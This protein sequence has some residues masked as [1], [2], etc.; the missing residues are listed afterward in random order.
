MSGKIYGQIS[1]R[2]RK[3]R[4][5]KE[6]RGEI[7]AMPDIVDPEE[8]IKR[9]GSGWT[10]GRPIGTV[11]EE[12]ERK[13]WEPVYAEWIGYGSEGLAAKY[14]EEKKKYEQ[15]REAY[16]NQTLAS[17]YVPMARAMPGSS[18]MH[19]GL[20]AKYDR[21]N[22]ERKEYLERMKSA[23][24]EW[25]A[26]EARKQKEE[27]LRV[28][29][30][31]KV[32]TGE[33]G[34]IAAENRTSAEK[35]LEGE[36][37]WSY[38]TEYMTEEERERFAYYYGTDRKEAE[39]YLELL[40]EMRLY[41]K[42]RESKE[43]EGE[44]IAEEIAEIDS[45]LL[46]GLADVGLAIAGGVTDAVTGLANFGKMVLGEEDMIISSLSH[47]NGLNIERVKEKSWM[48]G[49]L[50][51]FTSGVTASGLGVGVS[52]VTGNPLAGAAVMGAQ[53]SGNT[54]ARE[55]ESGKEADDARAYSLLIGIGTGTLQYLLGGIRAFG[56]SGGYGAKAA[57]K[58]NKALGGVVKQPVGRSAL[59][60]IAKQMKEMGKEAFEEY[61]ETTLEPVYR[62][63]IYDEENELELL[64]VEA[65]ENAF[66][67]ALTAGAL[68]LILPESGVERN[69]TIE[70][71]AADTRN[72]PDSIRN[73][74]DAADTRNTPNSIRNM[75]DAADMRNTPD[76]VQNTPDAADRA[77]PSPE[78]SA[79]AKGVPETRGSEL[80]KTPEPERY[81]KQAHESFDEGGSGSESAW[82]AADRGSQTQ[83]LSEDGRTG[84][85][86]GRK[87][88]EIGS[89]FSERG[90]ELETLSEA[91]RLGGKKL[92]DYDGE[93]NR[94]YEASGF[95]AESRADFDPKQ[96]PKGW[97]YE[98]QGKP[99][100][101]F[102][103]Y[104]G[105]EAAQA[106]KPTDVES[107]WKSNYE[108]AEEWRDTEIR[109]AEEENAN[110]TVAEEKQPTNEHMVDKKPESDI[111]KE[112]DNQNDY[113]QP[114]NGVSNV[115][116]HK[117]TGYVLNYQ[118]T[119]GVKLEATSGKTTTI[120]GRYTSDTA[121]II[122]ELGLEKSTDFGPRDGDFNLLNV[123]DDLYISAE[124]FW[125]EYNKPWLDAAISRGDIIK[126]AT[127]P[128]HENLYR[129]NLETGKEELSGFGREYMYLTQEC[130]Y[131]Y[132]QRSGELR[133]KK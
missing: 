121:A 27:K 66:V 42:Y 20:R 9:Q 3:E 2:L 101:L 71:D 6:A 98:K 45:W 63:L 123:P 68:N 77:Q 59:N 133:R 1:E 124:Q 33:Y 91:V 118:T 37:S 46:R 39:E 48:C 119:S 105:E 40:Q 67:G 13:K 130:G 50:L 125:E 120:L 103:R 62:N 4:K 76:M 112:E 99:D 116:S 15:E 78:L 83:Y 65:L 14:E 85:S 34:Q 126:I 58:A 10:S 17:N 43:K 55:L 22:A 75:A 16:I 87:D 92:A 117:G 57:G 25:S 114:N 12:E 28:Y 82:K 122:D 70:E 90:K 74:A 31:P 97:D 132:D 86:I 29:E 54:Y 53:T 32:K 38:E 18:D 5:E 129:I 113:H 60:G 11:A 80:L 81:Q 93:R 24:E 23:S 131:V 109:K 35:A 102:W 56:H 49:A 127:L 8:W 7:E 21:E 26:E 72:I 106:A 47:A 110:K 30:T 44:A 96:A 107:L 19:D 84:V 51:E 111:I 89:W 115:T 79:A 64:S 108:V 88:G 52:I 69:R 94:F 73:M 95:V 104:A 61:V 41:P 36:Y 100:I 128:I